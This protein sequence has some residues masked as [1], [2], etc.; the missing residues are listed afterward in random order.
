M[1]DLAQRCRKA[2]EPALSGRALLTGVSTCPDSDGEWIGHEPG[3][4]FTWRPRP[5]DIS[6]KLGSID[7]LTPCPDL[8]TRVS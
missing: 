6:S 8:A 1:T 2:P 7:Y 3:G 5:C 4:E